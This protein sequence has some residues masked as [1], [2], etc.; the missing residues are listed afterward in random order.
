M[1]CNSEQKGTVR[2]SGM[3]LTLARPLDPEPGL[4][5]R[6][7]AA[8]LDHFPEGHHFLDRKGDRPSGK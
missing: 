7:P 3:P 5:G 4:R 1:Y 8:P 2:F 6:V